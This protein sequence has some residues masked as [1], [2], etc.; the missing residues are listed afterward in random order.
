MTSQLITHSIFYVN[1]T[2]AAMF[3][4]IRSKPNVQNMTGIHINPFQ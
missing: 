2:A 4:S 3:E 1:Q